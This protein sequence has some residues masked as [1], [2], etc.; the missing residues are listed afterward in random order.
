LCFADTARLQN[1]TTISHHQLT[2][3]LPLK[4]K[5]P[6]Y[7]TTLQNGT[8]SVMINLKELSCKQLQY[9]LS[10]LQINVVYLCMPSIMAAA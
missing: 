2:I 9:I 6:R 8:G 4:W 3:M 7:E 10:F 1:T 5:A